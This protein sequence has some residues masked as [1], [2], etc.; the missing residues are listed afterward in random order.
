[1]KL[2]CFSPGTPERAWRVG[3]KHTAGDYFIHPG[4]TRLC[5]D[6]G[7]QPGQWLELTPLSRE[8]WRLLMTLQDSGNMSAR[9]GSIVKR[10]AGRGST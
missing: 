4:W 1:L 3:V 8:P 10:W 6:L 9:P 2:T 7:L 5:A